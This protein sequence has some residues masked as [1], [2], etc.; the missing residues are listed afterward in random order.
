ME[1]TDF[2]PT[3]EAQFYT[4]QGNLLSYISSRAAAYGITEA[5]WTALS[6]LQTDYQTKY[7][8]ATTA[9]TRTAATVLAKN[10]AH[11]AFV[12]AIRL[13]LKV[14]ITYNPAVSDD[15]RKNMVL[16]VHK[17]TRTPVPPP[18]DAVALLLRQ[19]TGNRVE[20]NFSRVSIDIADK[21]GHEAKPF[22]VRGVELRWAILP[23]PPKSH[24]DLVH[25]EFDT[26]SPYIFQ[27]DLPDAGKT[28]Y[29]CARWENTTGQKGPWN[30]IKSIIIP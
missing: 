14:H 2:I 1:N 8:I 22:G 26:R 16:P 4:W 23:E 28:L 12:K 11:D 19:L 21:E 27:F 29:I 24:A 30:E 20:V 9:A 5:E 17:T 7:A 25:S 18:T 15:D 10:Q 6:A 3:A 13:I